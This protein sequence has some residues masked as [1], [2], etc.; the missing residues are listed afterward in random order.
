MCSHD[1][2]YTPTFTKLSACSE[3]QA[4]TEQR[5]FHHS[6]PFNLHW[7]QNDEILLDYEIQ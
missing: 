6:D 4:F 7:P 1:P 5:I 2:F 3:M